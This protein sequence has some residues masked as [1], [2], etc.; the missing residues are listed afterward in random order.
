MKI[1]HP[2]YFKPLQIESEYPE[3]LVI[4]NA[5]LFRKVVFGVLEQCNGDDGD[6]VL[7]D[8]NQIL[9]FSSNC[10]L[11]TDVCRMDFNGRDIKSKIQ[12]IVVE[13]ISDE[14]K[15]R[16]LLSSIEQFAIEVADEFSYPLKYKMTLQPLDLVKFLNF[17]IDEE[18]SSPLERLI[19]YMDLYT[20]LLSRKLIVTV[21]LKDYLSKEEYACF[22]EDIRNRQFRLLMIERHVHSF[23]DIDHRLIVDQDLCEI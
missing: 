2:Y 20:N 21:N 7:S 8:H 19:D 22:S 18:E 9:E 3:T 5:E 4:E 6:F 10:V 1:A 23:D 17:E 13:E 11:I 12:K 14:D 15:T 16:L